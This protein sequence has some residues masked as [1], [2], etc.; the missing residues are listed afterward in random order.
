MCVHLRIRHVAFTVETNV[1]WSTHKAVYIRK[2]LTCEHIG[3][4]VCTVTPIITQSSMEA[5]IFVHCLAND[6]HNNSVILFMV[7]S[8]RLDGCKGNVGRSVGGGR[9]Y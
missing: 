3:V 8:P 5:S 7:K 4:C 1:E 9:A 2:T 6:F